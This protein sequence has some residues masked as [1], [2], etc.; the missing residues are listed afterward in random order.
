MRLSKISLSMDRILAKLGNFQVGVD[1][2][3]YVS[4]IWITCASIIVLYNLC[5]HPLS[6]FPGPTLARFSG[7]WSRIANFSG[8]KAERIHAAHERYGKH[9]GPLLILVFSISL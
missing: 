2:L 7:L 5:F 1:A 4:T 6:S 3:G 8:S 9:H